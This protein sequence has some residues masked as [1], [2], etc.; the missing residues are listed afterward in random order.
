MVG[1]MLVLGVIYT[2]SVG[3]NTIYISQLKQLHI[4][5]VTSEKV[6]SLLKSVQIKPKYLKI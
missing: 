4:R 3:W 1:V 2:E 6:E 5:P